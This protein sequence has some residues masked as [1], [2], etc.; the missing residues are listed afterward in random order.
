[1]RDRPSFATTPPWRGRTERIRPIDVVVAIGLAALPLTSIVGGVASS[2]VDGLTV[3]L[4]LLESLPL[5]V[6][7]RFPL[8]VFLVVVAATLVQLAIVPVG[9]EF[10]GGLGVLVAFYTVGERL[11]R[12]LSVPLVVLAGVIL[13]VVLL[14]RGG[15]PTVLQSAVQ[16]ELILAVAW[17]VGDASRI[18]HLYTL[19][20][21]EQTRMLEREREE[22]TQRAIL[23][24][25]ERIARELH[26]VVAHHAS[27]VVVQAGGALRA[28]DTRPEEARSAL[29]A[30]AATGRQ[31]L[32]EMRRLVGIL[33]GGG[34]Q[35][36]PRLEELDALVEQVRAAGHAVDLVVEGDRRPLDGGLELSAYRIVQEGLTN[37]LKHA[38]GGH[39]S[40]TVRFDKEAL[41]IT[42]DDDRPAEAVA[43]DGATA[44]ESEH[45]GRGLLGMRERVALFGGTFEAR[46]TATGFRV[47]ARLPIADRVAV[48]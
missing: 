19:A 11:D 16:T 30:I 12:Q 42:I 33:G 2:T 25:R 9:Q 23:E 41:G 7:R 32:T 4:L 47:I 26:D 21:E 37:S 13:A 18:R 20:M 15:F 45:D 5:I 3:V 38:A 8:E 34:G 24:E 44:V 35:P 17:L 10:L 1:M 14:G 28:F 39:T 46:P 29:E 43:T 40:V 36:A 31:A 27:V 48:T 6:R 22:R